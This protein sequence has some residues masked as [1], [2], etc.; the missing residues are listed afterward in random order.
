MIF[1]ERILISFKQV[2]CP[3]IDSIF[4]LYVYTG[5]IQIH[6]EEPEF[7]NRNQDMAISKIN[8]AS[9]WNY[10]ISFFFLD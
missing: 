3:K 7:K 9:L 1:L 5:M 2:I 10:L 4:S 8:F 6:R